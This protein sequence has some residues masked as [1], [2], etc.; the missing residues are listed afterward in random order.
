MPL[1]R[2]EIALRNSAIFIALRG[3]EPKLPLDQRAKALL[4]FRVARYRSLSSV[5]G[6]NVYVMPFAMASQITSLLHQF[7]D[8]VTPFHTSIPISFV[9]AI[10]RG[11]SSSSVIK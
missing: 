1:V 11:G 8:K 7:P 10:I 3:F 5:F 4:D 6:I 9:S 2:L